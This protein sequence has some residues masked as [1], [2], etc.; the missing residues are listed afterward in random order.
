MIAKRKVI[1]WFLEE[2]L[3]LPR[4]TMAGV[5]SD[6]PNLPH[7]FLN[8][9]NFLLSI[10][11]IIAILSAVVAGMMYFFSAGDSSKAEQAKKYVWASVVGLLI[12]LGALIIVR[13]IGQIV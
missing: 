13:Q 11:G 2:I 3:F 1:V 8:I 10:V 12:A 5:I 9:L 6:A 4:V 7:V